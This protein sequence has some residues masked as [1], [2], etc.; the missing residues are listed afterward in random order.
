MKGRREAQKKESQCSDQQDWQASSCELH[1]QEKDRCSRF[2]GIFD[3][4]NAKLDAG[5]LSQPAAVCR[6][7]ITNSL[8]RLQRHLLA[9]GAFERVTAKRS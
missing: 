1:L 8:P 2:A 5:T 3:P 7:R 9:A 6:E 4:N